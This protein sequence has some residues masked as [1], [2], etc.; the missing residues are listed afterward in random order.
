MR[1][2][3]IVQ[4]VLAHY[5]VDLFTR[6]HSALKHDGIELE[7]I[8]GR[9]RPGT[10][11]RTVD[12]D[13]PWAHEITNCY[14][15]IGDTELVWQPCLPRL[16][17]ADLVIVEQANRLLLNY[18]LLLEQALRR[19]RRVAFWGHGKDFQAERTARIR[20][21]VKRALVNKVDWW[22]AYTAVTGRII[23]NAGMR[24]DRI[25]ILNN[26]FDTTEL[27]AVARSMSPS[28]QQSLRAKLGIPEGSRVA[29]YCGG[30]RPGKELEY[31]LKACRAIHAQLP[32]FHVIF[33]GDGPLKHLVEEAALGASWIHA[34]GP[35][36]GAERARYFR[37]ADILMMPA[38]VGLAVLDSFAT[39]TPL[40]TTEST[41]H[42]PE[43]AYLADQRNCVIT[44]RELTKYASAVTEY[45]LEPTRL[46]PLR[47]GCAVA[48]R[49]YT[50]DKMVT[51][52]ATGIR[53]SLG[54]I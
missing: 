25:T 27:T 31:L 2:V 26:A 52:F 46:A 17:A 5:R 34:V 28:E 22:F 54:S 12:I 23:E 33:I 49:T 13:V 40:F 29:I 20:P 42:G 37:I 21:Y 48:S 6:L 11:P 45:L 43:L 30:M 3:V 19:D 38:E 10:V 39:Q 24:P 4:R 35:I 32:L 8:Y 15:S 18:V 47:E 50:L 14:V 9:E 36:F 41:T 51:N 7:V 1:R 16:R 53:E 44:R